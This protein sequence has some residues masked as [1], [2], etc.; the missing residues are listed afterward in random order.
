MKGKT[1]VWTA[2]VGTLIVGVSDSIVKGALMALGAVIMLR[3]LVY[4]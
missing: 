1:F 2:V 3:F 4:V